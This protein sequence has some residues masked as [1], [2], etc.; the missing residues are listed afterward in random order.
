[1]AVDI[2]RVAYSRKKNDHREVYHPDPDCHHRDRIIKNGNVRWHAVSEI[3]VGGNIT[4]PGGRRL[5]KCLDCN[6]PLGGQN[7]IVQEE[8]SNS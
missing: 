6:W 1:M 8:E 2:I 7:S 3:V 4:V 5:S